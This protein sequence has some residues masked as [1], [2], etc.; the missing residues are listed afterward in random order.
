MSLVRF[1]PDGQTV[2]VAAGSTILTAARLARVIVESP[3]NGV[4]TCGK[5]AVWLDTASRLAV[6]DTGMHHLPESLAA[7]GWVL[8]CGTTVHGDVTV[9]LR[10]PDAQGGVRILH[11]GQAI[12]VPLLPFIRK[13]YRGETGTTLLLAGARTLGM[14]EGD[15][16]PTLYGAVIDIGTTTLVASLIDLTSGEEI[17]STSALNPQALHAQDVL[18]RIALAKDADGLTLLRSAVCGEI[19]RLLAALE[20][21]TGVEARQIY[22]MVFSGNTCMLHLATDTNP[23]SLGKYPYTPT[24][25]G[26]EHRTASEVGIAIAPQGIVY[27]PPIISAFVGA[28]ITA[29]ILAADLA[30]RPGATLFIDIGTNGE[31][32]L[33]VDGQLI[34][35]STAAGPAFEGMNIS[36]GMRAGGGAIEACAIHADG[37]LELTVI[38]GGE[39]GGICGSGLVDIIGELVAHGVINAQGKLLNADSANV[40][41]RL[42]E[43]LQPYQG[44]PAFRLT[45]QVWLTQKDIR[46]LQL[47]K[48]AIRAGFDYLLKHAGITADALDA[49]FIAGSFGYHLRA[50]S[51]LQLGLLPPVA[52]EKVVF[53]GNTAKSGGVAFL[54]HAPSRAAIQQIVEAVEVLELANFPGFDRAFVACL[55][56]PTPVPARENTACVAG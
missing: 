12:R 38:G 55:G 7:E 44:K 5:C 9:S 20:A 23:A 43:R 24:L 35:T 2:E 25:Y 16:T 32:V 28:D 34:A 41:T 14:E 31:M 37:T 15:T 8:A 46:Q 33:A 53:L 11:D 21:Q 36:F 19:N 26:G 30:H 42:R 6:K 10:K 17:A 47:A 39:A 49:I 4:G 29:G 13:E 52:E 54:L 45:E 18:S 22:E 1:L 27:L 51:L 50:R 3:C 56:F 48:G 40:P